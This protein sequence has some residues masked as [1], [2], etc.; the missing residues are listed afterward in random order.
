M[1]LSTT[2]DDTISFITLT[3][4]R[5]RFP[6]AVLSYLPVQIIVSTRT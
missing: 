6:L 3:A 2:L 5:N 4:S 1:A